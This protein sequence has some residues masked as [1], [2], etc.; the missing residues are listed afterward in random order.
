MMIKMGDDRMENEARNLSMD[1]LHQAQV[2]EVNKAESLVIGNFRVLSKL[3]IY[4]KI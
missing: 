1:I 4:L 3:Q 2:I